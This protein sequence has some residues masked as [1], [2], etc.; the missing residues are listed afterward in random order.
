MAEIQFKKCTEVH[1]FYKAR[2]YFHMK[3]KS[4]S[5]TNF[6]FATATRTSCMAGRNIFKEAL[7]F[8]P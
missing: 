4:L 3:K 7:T 5:S 8:H 6:T 1:C 2:S